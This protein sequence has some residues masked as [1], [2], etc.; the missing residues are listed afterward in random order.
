[1][2]ERAVI[3]IETVEMPVRVDAPLE[4]T[5]PILPSEALRLGRLLFPTKSI[6]KWF[7][8]G[9]ACALGAIH[10]GWYGKAPLD[11]TNWDSRTLRRLEAFG[12]D[13]PVADVGC[14]LFDEAEDRGEDGDAA[15]LAY[16]E[17]LGL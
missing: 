12:I 17:S 2:T 3:D 13:R 9:G 8:L 1:M 5:T 14:H 11:H 7:R 16:L 4:P 6:G 10:A 15:V